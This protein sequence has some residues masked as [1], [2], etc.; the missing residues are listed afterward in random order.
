[1][2]ARDGKSEGEPDGGALEASEPGPWAGH[3]PV[4]V[5]EVLDVFA[6]LQAGVFVDATV[7]GG[8]HADAI[9]AAH[10]GLE[11]VGLDR[12]AE[13]IDAAGRRLAPYGPRVTL[14][15]CRFD[16]MDT[17]L[18]AI[19]VHDIVGLFLDLGVSSHQLDTAVR[20]FS[21]RQQ[22]PLD[23]RMDRRSG[24]NAADLVNGATERE[25][26]ELL[27]RLGDEKHAG[28]IARAVVAARP[29]ETTT[30]L[31]ELVRAAIPA[32]ARRH[33]GHPAKRT[34]QALRIAVN[35]ELAA[36]DKALGVALDRM[37][38][39][40]RGAVLTYHSGEDRIVKHRLRV[41][42]GETPRP[43]AGRPLPV[44]PEP[45]VRLLGRGGRTPTSD[46]TERNPRASSARLRAFEVIA[47]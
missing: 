29:V 39:G 4:M 33:G 25:L 7:G 28:R 9:L 38:V 15:H 30:E 26:A 20:G 46:E 45:R 3:E 5:A 31:A 43:P 13:A 19:G 42:A 36:L 32:A 27:R 34:F 1:M 11:L 23:M 24:L 21:Y 18:D 6:P 10:P 41:E 40:A 47:A 22:G 14:R 44:E 16:E 17:A 37:S 12:D 35:E 2:A 8:G